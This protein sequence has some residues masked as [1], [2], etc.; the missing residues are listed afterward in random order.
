[1]KQ[2]KTLEISFYLKSTEEVARNLI[3]AMLVRR[4]PK[5]QL[6]RGRIIETEAYLGFRDP[7]CHSYHGKLTSRVAPLYETGGISYVY[8]IYGLHSCLNVVTCKK[9]VP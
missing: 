6:L 8:L 5:G 2:F 3:G 9:G 4:L 7:A 1:M